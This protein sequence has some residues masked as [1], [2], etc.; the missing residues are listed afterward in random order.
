METVLLIGTIKWQ[1]ETRQMQNQ[2]EDIQM[3]CSVSALSFPLPIRLLALSLN[4]EC[5]QRKEREGMKG[6]E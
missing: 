1:L 4:V 2:L 5:E 6:G 3:R